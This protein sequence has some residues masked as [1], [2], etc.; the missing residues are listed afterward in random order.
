[1]LRI[2]QIIRAKMS[3]G[4]VGGIEAEIRAIVENREEFTKV[5]REK[6]KYAKYSLYL[7]AQ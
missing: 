7:F 3:A 5:F 1:M 6:Q 2:R 4:A